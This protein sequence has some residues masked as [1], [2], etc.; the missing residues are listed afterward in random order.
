[1]KYLRIGF[2]L[3]VLLMISTTLVSAAPGHVGAAV[4]NDFPHPTACVVMDMDL[5]LY[6][7]EDC[8]PK[9]GVLMHGTNEYQLF[10]AKGQLPEG[11]AL[12]EKGAGVITY[13]DTGFAC[14]GMGGV[15]TT[16]Y[17]IVITP[18]GKFNINCHFRPDKWKP[19]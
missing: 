3:M 2:V 16:N 11:A 6:W 19:D 13:A 14:W 10:A 5:V 9:H 15:Q 7:M 12:P 1:M 17:S 8:S 18:N 4:I